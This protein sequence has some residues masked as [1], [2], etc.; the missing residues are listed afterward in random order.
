MVTAQSTYH[1]P[2]GSQGIQNIQLIRLCFVIRTP[3]AH[4]ETAP[5]S[6]EQAAYSTSLPCT[7]GTADRCGTCS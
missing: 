3:C 1:S 4:L 6:N 5:A 2:N 7:H